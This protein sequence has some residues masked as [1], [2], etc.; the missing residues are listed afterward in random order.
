MQITQDE[1]LKCKRAVVVMHELAKVAF[2]VAGKPE[3]IEVKQDRLV[4]LQVLKR[5]EAIAK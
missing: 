3:A 4:L 5:L 2:D 1:L